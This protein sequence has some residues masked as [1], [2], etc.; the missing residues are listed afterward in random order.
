MRNNNK[1][2]DDCAKCINVYFIVWIYTSER[3]NILFHFIF[4]GY[5]MILYET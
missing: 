4:K 5:E 1:L 3:S 2:F